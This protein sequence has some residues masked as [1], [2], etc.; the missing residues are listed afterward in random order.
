MYSNFNMFGYSSRTSWQ[1]KILSDIIWFLLCNR[2][3][4]SVLQEY[5]FLGVFSILASTTEVQQKLERTKEREKEVIIVFLLFRKLP[6]I[7][8]QDISVPFYSGIRCGISEHLVILT[9]DI[10]YLIF[11]HWKFYEVETCKDRTITDGAVSCL[12]S[13][14]SQC[15]LESSFH[16]FVSRRRPIAI[17][18]L[19]FLSVMLVSWQHQSWRIIPYQ[20]SVTC[21]SN[22]V[23]ATVHMPSCV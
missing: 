2:R 7:V 10:L 12:R 1:S 6:L 14:W 4:S 13:W 18:M 9:V 21:L 22:I 15:W 5:A 8:C 16:I 11:W 17:N 19:V 3:F 20:I 23:L